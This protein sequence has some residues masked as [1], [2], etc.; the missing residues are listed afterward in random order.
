MCDSCSAQ[1][2]TACADAVR[3]DLPS[4]QVTGYDCTTCDNTANIRAGKLNSGGSG[5]V[6]TDPG[7]IIFNVLKI[8]AFF[9]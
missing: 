3:D 2:G 6:S 5:S 4:T 8:A 9:A 1:D 7:K